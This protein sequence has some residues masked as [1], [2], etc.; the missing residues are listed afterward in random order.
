MYILLHDR[1]RGVG[2]QLYLTSP[3]VPLVVA[4]DPLRF[5]LQVNAVGETVPVPLLFEAEHLVK[6]GSAVQ[7]IRVIIP[8]HQALAKAL[9]VAVVYQKVLVQALT[10]V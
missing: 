10:V 6:R 1:D 5:L 7:S 4:R 8:R 3:I 9:A 2:L